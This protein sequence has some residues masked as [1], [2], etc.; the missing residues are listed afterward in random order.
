[1]DAC[2]RLC[3]NQ[4]DRR[5]IIFGI[6]YQL[7]GIGKIAPLYFLIS[8]YTTTNPILSRTSGRPI[9]ASVAKALTPAVFIGFVIPTCL[10]FIPFEDL[11]LR[12]SIIA[13]WQPFPISVAILTSVI[14]A[15]IQTLEGR[16]W[17]VSDG[18]QQKDLAP[19]QA[20]YALTF[21]M[22]AIVHI[23]SISYIWATP[24]LSATRIFWNIAA[25][26]GS[27]DPRTVLNWFWQN[28]MILY[29]ASITAWTLYSV[30]DMRRLGYATTRQAI[31]AALTAIAGQ[32]LV[33]PGA[34]Y[35]GVWYWRETVI[36][37]QVKIGE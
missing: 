25:S 19:L 16:R 17:S 20:G 14:A 28:D 34:T 4:D 32:L 23:C 30:Y 6:A 9:P 21:F 35:A 22:T 15:A 8:V 24:S 12:Q 7:L 36:A 26:S 29:F 18:Y 13:I 10:M 3:S 31:S 11:S 2:R 5:P 33:G 27:A 37:S 1:M